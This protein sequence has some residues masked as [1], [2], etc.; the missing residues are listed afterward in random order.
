VYHFKKVLEQCFGPVK[1]ST[2]YINLNRYTQQQKWFDSYHQ[3]TQPFTMVGQQ[4]KK[5]SIE[6]STLTPYQ[7]LINFRDA[8]SKDPQAQVWLQRCQLMCTKW[9]SP[10]N[11]T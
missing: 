5:F 2:E 7:R 10:Q 1:S 6:N 8:R 3:Q 4:E 11:L 9:M